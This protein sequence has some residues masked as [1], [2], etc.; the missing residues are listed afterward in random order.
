M[1]SIPDDGFATDSDVSA[2]NV[3]GVA[4]KAFAKIT[5]ADGTFYVRSRSVVLGRGPFPARVI[6]PHE[7][8]DHDDYPSDSLSSPSLGQ[9]RKRKRDFDDAGPYIHAPYPGGIGETPEEPVDLESWPQ[10]QRV[11]IYPPCDSNGQPVGPQSISKEHLKIWWDEETQHWTLT[12]LGK[13]GAVL[14]KSDHVQRGRDI[15]ID[16]G[17]FIDMGRVTMQWFDQPYRSGAERDED[18]TSALSYSN[19]N[20]ERAQLISSDDTPES[21]VDGIT[22]LE[23]PHRSGEQQTKK[24]G[25]KR[26]GS[27][28]GT[29]QNAD[30]TP[31]KRGPGRPPADGVMSKRERTERARYE[32]NGLVYGKDELPKRKNN[33][34][35]KKDDAGEG[36]AE[37]A[38][39]AGNKT[40]SGSRS[41]GPN[42]EDENADGGDSSEAAAPSKKKAPPQPKRPVSPPPK[43]EDFTPE[44]LTAPT[45]NYSELL[46]RLLSEAYPT[47]LDLQEIYRK[48]RKQ[49]P[50]FNFLPTDGWQ[51]S[52]RH[53]LHQHEF[54][55]DRGK[56]GKGRLWSI[57][58]KIPFTNTDTKG[59]KKEKAPASASGPQ[60]H[61]YYNT[62][63]PQHPS[64]QGMPNQQMYRQ[65]YGPGQY[66][67][68]YAG[69]TPM[70]QRP[71]QHQ[72]P[73]PQPN[74]SATNQMPVRDATSRPPLAP[75]QAAN[76]S[77]STQRVGNVG[78][79]G[80]NPN[81]PN[82][83]LPN[84]NPRP[85]DH[86]AK[87]RM[88]KRKLFENFR[89]SLV[90]LA[91]DEATKQKY[92]QLMNDAIN[93]AVSEKGNG[94]FEH[95][96]PGHRE[97]VEKIITMLRA[98]WQRSALNPANIP[99]C[100]DYV[101][102]AEGQTGDASQKDGV[103]QQQKGETQ[104]TDGQATGA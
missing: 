81:H 58:P 61:Q 23:D 6:L 14:D 29:A 97:D 38:A 43:K 100:P 69:S 93:F 104:T 68:P 84:G 103:V 21:S 41:A 15:H 36:D 74:A 22:P 40:K 56:S 50:H 20:S 78:D 66:V 91:P 52:I 27:Q 57:D 24:S 11:N 35:R 5:F 71:G 10:E 89:G 62:Y 17:L 82:G 12:V 59:K 64:Q 75:G 9:A 90:N 85:V 92:H 4:E 53:N 87:L 102:P 51:S 30:G 98:S 13:N 79:V 49:W 7:A 1:A 45:G 80:V 99:G 83:T 25:P 46:Y 63:Q 31:K 70:Q 94:R 42:P 39:Q 34:P 54:L 55:V 3:D 8:S 47:S 32:K 88:L 33:K 73:Q 37:E 67:Q 101:A 44:Q 28:G 86:D 2:V 26:P 77:A 72:A 60:S 76:T 65:M 48:F 19:S 95:P 18:L 16:N 96:E